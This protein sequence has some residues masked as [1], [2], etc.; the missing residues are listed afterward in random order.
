MSEEYHYSF[1]LQFII[2][3]LEGLLGRRTIEAPAHLDNTGRK[4][5]VALQEDLIHQHRFIL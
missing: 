3:Q 5:S 2:A 1:L 4:V